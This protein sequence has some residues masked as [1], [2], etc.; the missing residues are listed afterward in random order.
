VNVIQLLSKVAQRGADIQ[1]VYTGDGSPEDRYA[2][3]LENDLWNV[4][5]M[6][7]GERFESKQFS[8]EAEACEYL[9][10]LLNRDQTI[11]SKPSS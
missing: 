11:W 9:L 10:D 7:R 5:Y 4:Y 8:T 6:E 2:I 3:V 1:A